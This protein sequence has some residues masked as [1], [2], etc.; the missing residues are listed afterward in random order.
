[1][2]LNQPHMTF[3]IPDSD[4]GST[5]I[6]LDSDLA[7]IALSYVPGHLPIEHRGPLAGRVLTKEEA[8][9]RIREAA[10][11]TRLEDAL[12]AAALRWR[13]RAWRLAV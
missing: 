5:V 2:N 11:W 9:P 12:A 8:E 4:P 1:M 6:V 7:F 3:V 10:P 13:R